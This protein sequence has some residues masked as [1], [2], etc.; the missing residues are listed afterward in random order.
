V[1]VFN[2]PNERVPGMPERR[3]AQPMMSPAAPGSDAQ[4]RPSV[5]GK[6]LVFKGELWAD[7]DLVLQGK[8]EGAIHHRQH[9]TVGTDGVVVGDIRARSILVEGTVEG[10]LHGSASVIVAA[11]AKVRGNIVAPRVGIMEGANFNGSVD[12]SGAQAAASE[13]ANQ[14]SHDLTLSDSSV[15]RV[16]Q[17]S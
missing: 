10:D 2:T 14:R 17:R 6:T 9:L 16:L 12:M 11:T 3:P 15:D 8:V 13:P 4:R 5:L 1:S 7:E